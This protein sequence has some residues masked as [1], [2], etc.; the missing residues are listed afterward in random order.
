M[1]IVCECL[2]ARACVC[3]CV[4]VQESVSVCLCDEHVFTGRELVVPGAN[5]PL[6]LAV[7]PYGNGLKGTLSKLAPCLAALPR[8]CLHFKL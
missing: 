4:F 1:G 5:H 7:N 2:C 3:V 8:D 6:T